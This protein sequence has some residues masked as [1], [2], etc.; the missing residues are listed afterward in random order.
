[1]LFFRVATIGLNKVLNSKC[2]FCLL[3]FDE[4]RTGG[5]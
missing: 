4:E 2:I 3:G 1:M 5:K